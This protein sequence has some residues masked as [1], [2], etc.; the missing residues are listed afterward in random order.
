MGS[1]LGKRRHSPGSPSICISWP[2]LPP[3]IVTPWT[4]DRPPFLTA[5]Y[6]TECKY[7]AWTETS[8]D[9]QLNRMPQ[10]GHYQ[11]SSTTPSTQAVVDVQMNQSWTWAHTIFTI[12]ENPTGHDHLAEE[13]D[14]QEDSD[15]PEGHALYLGD[16]PTFCQAYAEWFTLPY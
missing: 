9:F 12:H 8:P 11:G 15:Y 10:D 4:P 5:Y 14:F 1:K 6:N 16:P 2:P 3:V 7:P 13:D